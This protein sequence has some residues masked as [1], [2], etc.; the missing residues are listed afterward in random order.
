MLNIYSFFLRC[1]LFGNFSELF[2]KNLFHVSIITVLSFWNLLF[3]TFH[4]GMVESWDQVLGLRILGTPRTP[5][6]PTSLD[7]PFNLW[8][9]LEPHR[10][11]RISL[12]P[13]WNHRYSSGCDVWK[14]FLGNN[15][16][17]FIFKKLQFFNHKNFSMVEKWN[18]VLGPTG[19]LELPGPPEPPGPP[20]PW[21]L[22]P[23]YLRIPWTS[24]TPRTSGTLDALRLD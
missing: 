21:N 22:D 20:D 19:P 23:K 10:T 7:T 8:D 6:K 18:P 17:F 24:G 15:N 1:F 2:N 5:R 11:P 13:P 9:S 14:G 4:P 16:K 3:Y 12:G